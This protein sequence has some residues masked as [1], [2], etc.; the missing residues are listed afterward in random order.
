MVEAASSGVPAIFGDAARPGVYMDGA[1]SIAHVVSSEARIEAVNRELLM[2]L[3]ESG[4]AVVSSAP[5]AV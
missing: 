1:D 2:R 3:W 4:E 5:G